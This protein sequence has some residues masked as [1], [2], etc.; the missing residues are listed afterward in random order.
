MFCS[1]CSI[2]LIAGI[3]IAKSVERLSARSLTPHQNEPTHRSSE[4]TV[5]A[6]ELETRNDAV[7]LWQFIPERGRKYDLRIDH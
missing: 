4:F 1:A 7:G 2:V 3:I 6:N 5:T